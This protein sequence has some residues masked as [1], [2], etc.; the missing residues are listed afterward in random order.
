MPTV[1]VVKELQAQ[2]EETE[3]GH[4][5][6][7]SE[8]SVDD[9]A[10]NAQNTEDQSDVDEDETDADAAADPKSDT[11]LLLPSAF[12]RLAP[13]CGWTMLCSRSASALRAVS[14]G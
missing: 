6:D 5:S 4:E 8:D 2:R 1:R 3:D 9:V 12:S 14:A 7:Y 11:T 13:R 10:F